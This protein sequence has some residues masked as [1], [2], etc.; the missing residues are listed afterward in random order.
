MKRS[1]LLGHVVELL[2]T[3]RAS[4]RPAD[5]VVREFF[6]HRHYL[7][8]KDRRFIADALFGT[9]RH[10]ALLDAFVLA[11]L[12]A[13][14]PHRSFPSTPSAA[15]LLA[16]CLRV[17]NESSELLEQEGETLWGSMR[18]PG[19]F[20]TFLLHLAQA[21]PHSATAADPVRRLAVQTSMP[22]PVIR[23]WIG[24]WGEEEAG[25]LAESL[26]VQA[27]TTIRVNTLKTDI[28][29]CR[30]SLADAGV[31]VR[32]TPFAPAGF[33]LEKRVSIESLETFRKGFFEMQD[34]GSQLIAHLLEPREGMTVCDACAGGGGKTLHAAMLMKNKGTILASDIDR[35]RLSSLADRASRAGVDI[36]RTFAA[37]TDGSTLSS[38]RANADAVLV[39]APCSGIGTYRRNPGLKMAYSSE[40]SGR[41]GRT[42]RSLLEVYSTIVKPGGRLVYS[43]CTLVEEENEGVVSAFLEAHPE[44]RLLDA[45][46]LLEK[47]GI[48]V[49]CAPPFLLLL[50]HRTG[51]DGFFAA[52]MERSS[53][54][55]TG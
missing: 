44:F 29:T 5:T 30:T 25:L 12:G 39:D 1:S 52:V 21:D 23:E 42:Q 48:H 55:G 10:H 36:V 26:N 2:D 19:T 53:P 33:V 41:F 11:A 22:A 35:R 50:P 9:L 13:V 37:L 14:D 28:D 17:Q 7:G 6:R 46:A 8:S 49:P 34:E 45:G 54:G 24:R 4:A 32:P 27:P 16:Y 3:V 51:T 20:R 47:Q 43:T 31:Q 18:F 15:W 40:A 38:L